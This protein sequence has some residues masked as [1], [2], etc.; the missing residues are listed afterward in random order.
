M[1]TAGK[2]VK[3]E[4]MLIAIAITFLLGF[5]AG[6]I[7]TVYKLGP[8]KTTASQPDNATEQQG[9]TLNNEQAQAITALEAE[10]E[11]NH[12][13]AE[14]WT[15]LGNLYYDTN[16]SQKAINAY[17]HALELM[18]ANADILTD[19]GVM[20]R[21]NNQPEKALES[22]NKAIQTNP[23]HEPSRLNKGIVLLYDLGRIPEALQA[24]QELLNINSNATTANGKSVRE[25][26]VEV[27]KEIE[28]AGKQEPKGK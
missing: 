5:L 27:K 2:T 3:Q 22:F 8:S 28:S 23:R 14:A 15:R 19:L 11:K 1:T 25:L 9:I 21:H 20:Y 26:I 4:T 18:P 10:V 7:F 16:Q 17:T 12:T 24:W 6:T 13:N